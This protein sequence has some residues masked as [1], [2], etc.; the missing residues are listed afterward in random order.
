MIENSSTDEIL[1]F[2]EKD[3]HTKAQREMIHGEYLSNL[4]RTRQ[5]AGLNVMQITFFGIAN[6]L[7][8]SMR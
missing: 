1:C 6:G 7:D 2:R 8:P 5:I 3:T 4:K